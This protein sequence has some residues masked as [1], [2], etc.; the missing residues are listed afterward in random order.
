[1]LKL[2]LNAIIRP[3]LALPR[4]LAAFSGA[5]LVVAYPKADLG[6][7]AWVALIPL[8]VAVRERGLRDGFW[9]GWLAGFVF[10]VGSLYWLWHVVE[11]GWPDLS[12]RW[13]WL[14]WPSGMA[15]VALLAIYLAVYFGLWGLA[16]AA[17]T[18][19][20]SSGSIGGNLRMMMLLCAAWVTQEWLRSHVITGFPWNLLGASQHAHTGV[21]L[22]V[23][24]IAEFTGVY[25]I[26]FLMC[27]FNLA[28]LF[29]VERFIRERGFGRRVHV[30]FLL[31]FALVAIA[32]NYGVRVVV[33]HQPQGESFRVALI[34]PNIPQVMKE[35]AF[36]NEKEMAEFSRNRL[37]TL[38]EAAIAGSR[39]QLILWPETATPGYFR[40]DPESFAI[41]SNLVTRSQAWLMTGSMDADGL[42]NP[43]TARDYNAVFLVRPSL[44]IQKPYRKMHLVPFGEFV[45]LERW[46]PF[47]KYVIPIPGSFSEGN[48]YVLQQMTGPNVA[49]GPL[50]CFEDTFPYLARGYAQRGA[51]LLV[52]V[53]NDAWYKD[54]AGAIQHAANAV[55]RA[56]ETRTPLLRCANNG[57]S[58]YIDPVG[59][60]VDYIHGDAR[61]GIFVTAWK[62]LNVP[63][64]RADRPLTFYARYG[65]V[66][67]LAC[68]GLT[69]LWAV[70]E[71]GAGLWK[72]NRVKRET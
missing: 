36:K 44:T 62:T 32:W 53:T 2:L 16:V 7:V 63:V 71:I 54:S 9:L 10:F 11:V 52:N 48:E 58:G 57:L 5:L 47:M 27:F 49:M 20:F 18:P 59:R 34:Q 22:G 37:R 28:M 68:I 15:L 40:Y 12:E 42:D 30:E 67:A 31:A 66:F 23:A 45:P 46:L 14:C 21:S 24:Q 13:N 8:F 6:A 1:V 60:V 26:S 19:R 3:D 25:G 29:T 55:F 70:A 33:R 39:P 56:I 72:R 51:Q 17:A 50:I 69:V 64:P 41:I 61:E 65:D 38:T 43:K 4:L 35:A